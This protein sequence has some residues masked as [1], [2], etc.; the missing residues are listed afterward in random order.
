MAALVGFERLSWLAAP[1]A[2]A[3]WAVLTSQGRV[4]GI[5][6]ARPPTGPT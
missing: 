2:L 3:A 6:L 1:F 4:P 5:G